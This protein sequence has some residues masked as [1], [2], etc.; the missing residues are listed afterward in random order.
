MRQLDSE[1]MTEEARL[2]D[3]KR[4]IT[5]TFMTL[6]LGGLLEFAEKVTVRY[7]F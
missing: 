3:Y 7:T 1:I 5:K 2:G 6:K 4:Q